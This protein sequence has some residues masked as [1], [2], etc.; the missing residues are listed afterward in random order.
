MLQLYSN[1]IDSFF[2]DSRSPSFRLSF[3]FPAIE[4]SWIALTKRDD[5]RLTSEMSKFLRCRRHLFMQNSWERKTDGEMPII[6]MRERVRE[7]LCVCCFP[8]GL[9]VLHSHSFNLKTWSVDVKKSETRIAWTSHHHLGLFSPLFFSLLQLD[10]SSL[11]VS[12]QLLVSE[13]SELQR[14]LWR[15]FVPVGYLVFV[16]KILWEKRK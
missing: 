4:F 8:S 10:Y 12:P 16:I 3:S 6:C 11:Q 2:S 7:C 15:F 13:R 14:S 1:L 5:K 9:N